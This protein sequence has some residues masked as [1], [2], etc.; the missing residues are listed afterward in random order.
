MNGVSTKMS[1][2]YLFNPI[3][4]L[5][6]FRFQISSKVMISAVLADEPATSRISI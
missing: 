6:N 4:L 5:C 1:Q 3:S 2:K